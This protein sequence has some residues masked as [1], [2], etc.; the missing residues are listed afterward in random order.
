MLQPPNPGPSTA[1]HPASTGLRLPVLGVGVDVAPATTVATRIVRWGDARSSRMVC[2]C[3]VHAVVTAGSDAGFA[4]ALQVADHVA[5]DGAPVAWMLRRHGA[6]SQRR[7]AGPDLMALTLPLAAGNG[8]SVFLYGSTPETLARLQRQ[9]H[10]RWP[11]LVVAG[12][13]S[14]PFREQ[15]ADEIDA[16][17]AAINRSGAGIVWVGLGCPKQERWMAERRGQV[18]AVMV[19]VGA[20]FDFL[21]GRLPRAPQWMRHSGLEWLFRL[22]REPRR[23][24]RRYLVTNTRFMLG[25]MRQWWRER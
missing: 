1:A 5:P 3:N 9:L 24:A 17:V 18:Q 15:T 23:L 10:A 11:S 14:P 16:D 19:G 13:L 4:H 25:A 2:L 21:S 22:L 7:V 12:A 8:V 20:A 6:A